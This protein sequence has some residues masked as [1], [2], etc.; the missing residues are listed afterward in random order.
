MVGLDPAQ[1]EAL[2]QGIAGSRCVLRAPDDDHHLVNSAECHEQPGHDVQ[3]F[4]S[5]LPAESG[6]P[7][8]DLE[9]VVDVVAA[10]VV[11]PDRSR[12]TVDQHDVVDPERLLHRG[13]AV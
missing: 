5:A 4:L 2:H 3:P 9:A 11:Q 6:T 10:Q 13:Q 8:H 1:R 7:H 12:F